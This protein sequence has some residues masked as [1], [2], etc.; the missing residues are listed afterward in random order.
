MLG[1]LRAALAKDLRLLV[2]DRVGL[3]FL[4]L[5]PIV[6]ISV[7]G[8]SLAEL[9]GGG[10]PHPLPIVDEDGGW[11]GRALHERV[12]AEPSLNLPAV[13][14]R[15][16][17]L[18][19]VRRRAAG[20]VLVIPPGTSDAVASGRGG[21]LVLLTD[22]VRTVEVAQ[23]RSVVQ[24]L[25]HGLETAAAARAQSELGEARAA[26]ER[27]AADL[28]RE[29]DMLAERVGV[30]RAEAARQAA[31]A[32][33][34]LRSRLAD[35]AAER[36][37]AVR[38]RLV[39]E[40]RPLQAFLHELAA[41]REAFAAW[42]AAVQERAG[43]FADRLPPP[44]EPPPVPPSVAELG[45]ADPGTLAARILPA[46]GAPAIPPLPRLAPPALS[47]LRVP[48]LPDLPAA[49]L[50]GPLDIDETSV[51]GAPLRFNTFDQ[52]VPGFSVTFL[53]LGV[54]LGVSLGL[55]DERDWGTLE[56]LRA[57]PTPLAAVLLAKLGA[58]F[59]IGAAQMGLLFAVG[60]LVFGISLGPEPWALVLPTAGIV[61]A[62][63]AFG[64]VVAGVTPSREAVLPVGSIAILTMAAIGG[65][66]W[67]IDLEP[68]WMRTAALAFPTTWAMEAYN[69]LMI[70]REAAA[71]VLPQTGVLFAYGLAYLALG[72]ALF[73]RRV[74]RAS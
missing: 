18:A 13:A 74:L 70:R 2:R 63:T 68:E 41:R 8:L 56:R 50:P 24:E 69:D 71:A 22:P 15:D 23:A 11:V 62:A 51:S 67:P 73:R 30:V 52:N 5:A 47:T 33:R 26:F 12:V 45:S 36:Q 65:C 38:A 29:L 16:A 54:L 48:S 28:R 34:E 59:T 49:R 25:R 46:D 61:F 21:T 55:L 9:Y 37:A 72:L 19:M 27:S 1:G 10:S 40:L 39:A 53:L 14:T 66:W 42:L 3:V 35:A 7:A 20:A 17:A 4:A 60:R 6:V 44:P 57:T 64:L 32:E 43:R 58:R 31:T